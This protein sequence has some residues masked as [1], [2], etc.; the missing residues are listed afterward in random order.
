[1]PA[2]AGDIERTRALLADVEVR[3]R[4]AGSQKAKTR[5]ASPLWIEEQL[6]SLGAIKIIRGSVRGEETSGTLPREQVTEAGNLLEATLL[7]LSFLL[8]EGLK[9]HPQ[10]MEFSAY[11][12]CSTGV[13]GVSF[14]TSLRCEGQYE[15][16]FAD[17]PHLVQFLELGFGDTNEVESFGFQPIAHPTREGFKPG[18]WP[19]TRK[20]LEQ[21]LLDY[22]DREYRTSLGS[23]AVQVLNDERVPVCRISW[24]YGMGV[25]LEAPEWVSKERG[26]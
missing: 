22:L 20:G 12:G 17:G 6:R 2:G 8:E 13:S 15:S 24:G 4:G 3:G 10:R 23:R 26:I 7:I 18:F 5:P 11:D 25:L 19:T 1:M 16:D 14:G 9:G 21:S